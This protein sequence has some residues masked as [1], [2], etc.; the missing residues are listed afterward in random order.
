MSSG[1]ELKKN[2][3]ISR[4]L[5]IRKIRAQGER[6]TTRQ[7][8]LTR[9]NNEKEPRLA[10]AITRKVGNSVLRNRIKRK[11]RELFRKNKKTFGSYDYFFFINR[12][13]G[14]FKEEEWQKISGSIMDWCLK[15]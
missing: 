5:E 10:I 3:R 9:L 13:V 2:E 6:F 8:Q 4:S 7:F 14:P 11:I 15:K 12:P 1:L